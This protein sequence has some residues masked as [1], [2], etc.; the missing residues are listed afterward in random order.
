MAKAS[1]RQPL[2]QNRRAFMKAGGAHGSVLAGLAFCVGLVC[3]LATTA[4]AQPATLLAFD[5][6]PGDWVGQ[7]RKFTLTPADGSFSVSRNYDQ[8]V[9]VTFSGSGGFWSLDFAAPGPVPLVP[10]M[11]EAAT[12]WP[13]QSA[14]EPGLSVSGEGR[15]CNQLTGRFVVLEAVYG[16]S[17]DVERFAAD[18]EQHCEGGTPALFGS[19]RYNS[20]VALAP[21][22][23]ASRPSA[24]EGDLGTTPLAIVVS[25]SA[26]VASP[27]SVQYRTQDATATA[28][29]DYVAVSG[30]A[31][32][33]AGHTAVTVP[34]GVIGDA[35][36]EGDETFF[37]VL[38]DPQGA[39]LA[40]GTGVVTILDDDPYKTFLVFDSQPGDWIGQGQ[41]FTLTPV[42]GSITATR[43]SNVVTVRFDGSTWW[44]LRFA[45]PAG[46]T[47]TPG[48]YEG[49]TRWPFQS[50]TGPGL[51][52]SGDGRGC[53]TLT[54]RFVVLEAV[55]D[56]LGNLA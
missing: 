52:V 10:G 48:V 14:T 54:G 23:S 13:F 19:V 30:T 40:F 43:S 32:I 17:D 36:I 12:R 31:V 45:A 55:V 44:D 50:P 3:P 16:A 33:P 47:I 15:G 18:Y 20:A 53:N 39:P 37:F 1:S 8:G 56:G 51:D 25:L 5:S 42:D 22:L 26:P 28:G 49:A 46:A 29:V 21:R 2:V 38:E 7:G 41:E 4:G 6:Q 11:Y 9:S 24:Y 27:V 34:V 35:D